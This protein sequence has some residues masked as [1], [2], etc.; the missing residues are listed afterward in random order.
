MLTRATG[1]CWGAGDV[2]P[3]DAHVG[4]CTLEKS[5][6]RDT[7]DGRASLNVSASVEN[8]QNSFI[9]VQSTWQWVYVFL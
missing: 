7:A 8:T 6:E 5:T 1:C 9:L 4:V 3:G 2:G